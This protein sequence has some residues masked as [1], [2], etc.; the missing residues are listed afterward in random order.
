MRSGKPPFISS[1]SVRA[2]L[3]A[4]LYSAGKQTRSPLESLLIVDE[5][6][7]K[8]VLPD[9]EQRRMHALKD[10][11][12][13]IIRAQV[14]EH[15][16]A[17]GLA[18]PM[19]SET[20]AEA[21]TA[22]KHVVSTDNIELLGWNYLY[23]RYVRIDLAFSAKFFSDI[24][25]MTDRNLRRYQQHALGRLVEQIAQRE[26]KARQEQRKRSLYMAL[27]WAQRVPLFGRALALKQGQR[28]SGP[29]YVSGVLGV[30]KTAF[31][32]EL[33]RNWIDAAEISAVIWIDRPIS[34]PYIRHRL[35]ENL[36]QEGSTLTLRETLQ[37]TPTAVILDDIHALLSDS[38]GL[39]KVLDDLSAAR[40]CITNQEYVPL[41]RAATHI[42]LT[43]LNPAETSEFVQTLISDNAPIPEQIW[44]R[45]AGNPLLIRLIAQNPTYY[46]AEYERAPALHQLLTKAYRALPLEAK[47][48]WLML[49]MFAEGSSTALA[50]LWPLRFLEAHLHTLAQ[51][52]LID[53]LAP[54]QL[55]L[56]GEM[57]TFVEQRVV[58][59]GEMQLLS[60]HLI[61]EAEACFGE[62]ALFAQALAEHLLLA[63]WIQ[64]DA[65][66]VERWLER[67]AR[68]AAQNGAVWCEIFRRYDARTSLQHTSYGVCLR[69]SAHWDEAEEHFRN[70]V[71]LSGAE[72]KFDTQ[73]WALL[74]W[75]VLLRYRGRYQKAVENLERVQNMLTRRPDP[76]LRITMQIEFA[77]IAVDVG[78]GRRAQQWLATLP[79]TRRVLALHSEALLLQKDYQTSLA[80][81]EAALQTIKNDQLAQA[82]LYILLGRIFDA[83]QQHMQ[84]HDAFAL[85]VTLLE[86][87]NDVFALGRALMNLGACLMKLN[88]LDDAELVLQQAEEI[89]AKLGDMMA[90]KL[91]QYNRHLLRILRSTRQN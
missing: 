56:P 30:G 14:A 59:S 15:R 64:L 35:A 20:Y 39:D 70:A 12:V 19:L 71:T 2:V 49:A 41:S 57:R 33:V 63:D 8:T 29:V 1:E 23:Y 38:A 79:Q 75:A 47:A 90:L 78:D 50:A 83:Q 16:R 44:E 40:V 9:V 18:A 54:D 31:V 72:G 7:L 55:N 10:L 4:L 80:L 65:S 87:D 77:Q 26:G 48:H 67:F 42:A 36:S 82:R 28:S 53:F 24:F 3:E 22:L 52:R 17:V 13:E 61:E 21:A 5:H 91:T 85:A 45:S 68:N 43:P 6:L 58:D 37:L 27:P 74:E 51:W 34:I 62:Q 81:A 25:A 76:T 32:Q 73:A 46:S 89:Q 84:A 88:A 60:A 86:Q 11:I 66:R 69:R